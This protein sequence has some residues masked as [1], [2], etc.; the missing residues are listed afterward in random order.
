MS[1]EEETGDL[2]SYT[3]PPSALALIPLGNEMYHVSDLQKSET[4]NL[5]H[6]AESGTEALK[7]QQESISLNSG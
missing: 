5:Q 7:L 3:S 6:S 1:F 4:T 2:G